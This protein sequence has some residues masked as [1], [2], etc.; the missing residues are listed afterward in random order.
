MTSRLLLMRGLNTVR[1]GSRALDSG[2]RSKSEVPESVMGTP[3]LV[4][5]KSA[6]GGGRYLEHDGVCLFLG[7]VL[8]GAAR[9]EASVLADRLLTMVLEKLLKKK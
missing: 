1:N 8:K 7:R 2:P 5:K 4:T 6:E 9:A 3:V